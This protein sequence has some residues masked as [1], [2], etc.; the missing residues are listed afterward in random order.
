LLVPR[1][2]CHLVGFRHRAVHLFIDHPTAVEYTLVQ[3]RG[4]DKTESPGQFDLPTAGH[5]VGL[6]TT[7][8]T[9]I[10]E[11]EEELGLSQD[12]ILALQPVGSYEY[13][14]AMDEPGFR[15]VEFRAIYIGCL[16]PD[17]LD[18]ARFVD[19]E[20]AAL[21]VFSLS[22]IE[23]LIERFPERV[24]SGLAGSFPM[25]LKNKRETKQ[26][27]IVPSTEESEIR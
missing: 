21:S 13:C 12:D 20:V 25:Y 2:L 4:F 8:N 11:L 14:G 10:K 27:Q 17:A 1:W 5:V 3:V 6:D 9:L 24:A 15:N 26:A 23:T 16:K 22:E 7:T 18:K 19:H